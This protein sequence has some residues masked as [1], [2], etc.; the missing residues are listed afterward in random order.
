VAQVLASCVLW[1]DGAVGAAGIGE[2]RAGAELYGAMGLIP[3]NESQ[4]GAKNVRSGF[5]F[6]FLRA[7]KDRW[8]SGL[9]PIA[10]TFTFTPPYLALHLSISEA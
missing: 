4:E 6:Q 10:V 5:L 2:S 7:A 1:P 8:R 9:R 3:G